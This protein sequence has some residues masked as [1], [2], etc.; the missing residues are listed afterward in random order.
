MRH[1]LLASRLFPL[2]RVHRDG[3]VFHAIDTQNPAYLGIALETMKHDPNDARLWYG[4][5]RMQLHVGDQ[6]GY[7]A[8]LTRLKELTPGADYHIVR[9]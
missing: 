8:A 9:R 2:Q 7:S 3:P 6:T 5:A 4:V 1:F